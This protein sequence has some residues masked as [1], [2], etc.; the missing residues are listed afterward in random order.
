L[1]QQGQ[2]TDAMDG[3][4]EKYRDLY[5]RAAFVFLFQEGTLWD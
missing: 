1:H 5:A 2:Q 4:D 3:E